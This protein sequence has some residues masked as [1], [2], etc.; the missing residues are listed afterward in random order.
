M[1]ANAVSPATR[2][3]SIPSMAD[4]AAGVGPTDEEAKGNPHTGVTFHRSEIVGL[5]FM[6]RPTVAD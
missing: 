2:C 1:K 6:L 5:L 4:E 3:A